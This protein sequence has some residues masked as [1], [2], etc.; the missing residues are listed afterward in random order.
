M[1]SLIAD[2]IGNEGDMDGDTRIAERATEL[3]NRGDTEALRT[4]V[5]N[6]V[7]T[8]RSNFT[9]DVRSQLAPNDWDEIDWKEVSR[10]LAD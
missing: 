1:T 4:Y 3:A 9:A 7:R 8:H 2:Y 5:T 10:Q 6:I